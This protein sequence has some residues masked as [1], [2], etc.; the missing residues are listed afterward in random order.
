MK[1]FVAI[2]PSED[3][4]DCLL[5]MQ[6]GLLSAKWVPFDNFHLTL[7]YIGEADRRL[8]EDI[9]SALS[10]IIRPAPEIE[11]VGAGAFGDPRVRAA[12]TRAIWAGVTLTEDLATL[13]GKVSAALR[14]AGVNVQRRRY[15]PHVTLAYLKG[16]PR[17][18][19]EAWIAAN[20]LVR[21][22]IFRAHAFHL[23][24]S[25]AGAS[26]SVYERLGSYPLS[27]FSR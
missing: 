23:Y 12:R 27:S 24:A 19:V 10:D 11:I 20:A 17:P 22:P 15:H 3:A 5:A 6:E 14:R 4:A 7:D 1:L 9:D 2:D 18:E 26:G 13:Q 8:T 21:A 16:V 25:H